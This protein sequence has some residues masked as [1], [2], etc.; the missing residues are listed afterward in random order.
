MGLNTQKIFPLFL[1]LILISTFLPVQATPELII[2][3]TTD[4]E[5]YYDERIVQIHG[6]LTKDGSPVNTGLVA[7]Q[8]RDPSQT[9]I[10]RTLSTGNIPPI[11]WLVKIWDV[12]PSDSLG[13]PKDSFARG[14]LAHFNITVKNIDIEPHTVLLTINIYDLNNAPL[15]YG[16]VDGLLVP[17]RTELSEVLQV[18]IPAWA[19]IGN[20]T[21]YAN[22]YTDYPRLEGTPYCPE[23][24]ATFQI[25]G[26]SQATTPTT[27]TQPA[28]LDANGT[29]NLNFKLAPDA[30]HGN[31]TVYV[32][33]SYQ[34][35]TAFNSTTFKVKVLG[36]IDGDVDVDSDD[37]FLFREAYVGE[38]NPEADLNNDGNIDSDDF[39]LF[40]EAYV[41]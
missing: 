17:N 22:A 23:V 4:R 30:T 24:S 39:F 18:D 10:L 35:Q 2:T 15:C 20:A 19:A 6:S 40:R 21:A 13:N 37:F 41:G 8:V 31:Y 16:V 29:Y 5:G 26:G 1:F 38:Y 27:K 3:V 14:E 7:L 25:T 12:F 36:D 11:A 32:S 9:F 28:T 33:T 34:G